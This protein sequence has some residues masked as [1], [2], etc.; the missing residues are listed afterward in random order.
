MDVVSQMEKEFRPMTARIFN[1]RSLR[2]LLVG[3]VMFSGICSANAVGNINY[4]I[5]YDVV[6]T[7]S[8]LIANCKTDPNATVHQKFV[9]PRYSSPLMQKAARQDLA[10]MRKSGFESVRSIV[11]L[12]PGAHPSGDLVNSGKVDDS[13]LAAIGDYVRDVRDAGFKEL[14]LAFG[15]QGTAIPACR[16]TEWGD[17]FDPASITASVDAEANIISSALSAKG[18]LLLRVDLLNEACVSSAVPP[19]ANSNF[20]LFIRA[21]TKMHATRFPSTPA[22]VSCQL[23]RASDGLLVTQHLFADSGD[24]IG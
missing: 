4:G 9:V 10:S 5:N 1:V 3:G 24:R 18:G 12:F 8:N 20:T 2:P 14:I 22:T 16:K 13:V 23:E 17:C 6:A 21:A 7:D 15:T 19:I 11:Q